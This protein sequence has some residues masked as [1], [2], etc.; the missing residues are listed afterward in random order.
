MTNPEEIAELGHHGPRTRDRL[1]IVP[2]I[3]EA[4]RKLITDQPFDRVST[5]RLEKEHGDGGEVRLSGAWI[6]R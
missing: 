2:K 6:P 4:T 1:L 5:E 3:R